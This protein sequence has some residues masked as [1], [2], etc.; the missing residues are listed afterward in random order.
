MSPETMEQSAETANVGMNGNFP[1]RFAVVPISA[2]YVDRF[3][4][5]LDERWLKARQGKLNPAKLQT[6]V[7]SE[8]AHGN[9]QYSAV[10]GQHRIELAKRHG[11]EELPAIVYDLTVEEEAQ[12]FSDLQR[13]RR[14]I[15]A[16]Q[17]FNADLIAGS[18]QAHAIAKIVDDEGFTLGDSEGGGQLKAIVALERIYE[19]DPTYLRTVLRLVKRTWGD[20]PGSQ[21]ERMLRALWYFLRGTEDLNE[22]RFVERL[23][24]LTPSALVGR[25]HNLREFRGMSGALPGYLAEAIEDQYRS[26]RQIRR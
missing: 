19:D 24:A 3:Q 6:I 9:K 14:S 12:L 2:I 20:L 8:R 13:E 10:D 22:E 25:A 26:K 1:Y 16:Y 21:N 4:R 11:L 18:E 15:T 5:P 7:L 23:S 17:R